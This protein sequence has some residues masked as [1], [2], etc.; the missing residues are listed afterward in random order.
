MI[1]VL[2]KKKKK[3]E[4]DFEVDAYETEDIDDEETDEDEEE[5]KTPLVKP[6]KQKK[7]SPVLQKNPIHSYKFWF[8][9]FGAILLIILG[10][11]LLFRQSDSQII[12]L[13]FTGGVF[14]LYAVMRVIPLMRTLERGWSRVLCFIEVLFD[15][16]VGI[17]LIALSVQQ[18]G[19]EQ[20]GIV[21]Y[22]VEHY[23]ILIGVV[24]WLRGFVYFT[25]T[26]LFGEK[27]DRVQFFVHIAVI[28][29]GSFLLGVKID[30]KYIAIAIAIVSFISAVAI[31]GEGFYDYGK[32]RKQ[33]KAIREKKE[34]KKEKGKEAPARK[35][36]EK[37]E[38][39]EKDISHINDKDNDRPYV[40]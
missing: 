8:K 23:N 35:K 14:S 31:G 34:P 20:T 1:F 33:V 39:P 6:K 30:A 4:E 10:F 29:F 26:I 11:F 15:L 9:I 19:D 27:T 21:K 13:M 5:E 28:T 2:F 7:T 24:L 17:L 22:F 25:T 40:S 36:K 18:F 37:I 12:V 38:E 32:Y 3:Q 16:A